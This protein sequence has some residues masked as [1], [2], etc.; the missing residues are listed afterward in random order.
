MVNNER[1]IKTYS[2]GVANI[3]E[4]W[5]D[6]VG[7]ALLCNLSTRCS[8]K[9]CARAADCR[10]VDCRLKVCDCRA[11]VREYEHI[12]ASLPGRN[13]AL[14]HRTRNLRGVDCGQKGAYAL[15]K[16]CIGLVG[17]TRLTTSRQ[18]SGRCYKCFEKYK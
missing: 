14:E 10:R 18:Q 9:C 6:R 16:W 2:Q 15:L 12:I 1:F 8:L 17:R 3:S 7:F 4:I 5:V 11:V 13:I